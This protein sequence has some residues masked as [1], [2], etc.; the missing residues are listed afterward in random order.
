[1]HT[2]DIPAILRAAHSMNPIFIYPMAGIEVQGTA[3]GAAEAW[4]H[5]NSPAANCWA[6]CG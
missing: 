6:G 3:R 4:K 1:M 5:Q 2:V